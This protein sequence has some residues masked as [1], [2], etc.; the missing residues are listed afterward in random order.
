MSSLILH[1]FLYGWLSQ[2][3]L[4]LK[5]NR[6]QDY[7][8]SLSIT[9]T[10]LIYIS[11]HIFVKFVK[12]WLVLHIHIL[13]L[14]S[15]PI[16]VLRN[17]HAKVHVSKFYRV[18]FRS[19]FYKEIYFLDWTVPPT[20]EIQTGPFLEEHFTYEQI[21]CDWEGYLRKIPVERR[22]ISLAEWRGKFSLKTGIFR[23]YP[24]QY[25]ICLITPN[26]I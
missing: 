10:I 12:N 15:H 22:N 19:E 2:Y 1:E 25:D 4:W 16:Y 21:Y 18:F 23:K 8:F 5:W 6:L 9:N 3:S 11:V 20:F 26:I 24:S 17:N 13:C 14:P 7:C